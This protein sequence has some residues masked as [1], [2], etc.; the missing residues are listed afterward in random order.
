MSNIKVANRNTE[1]Q[2]ESQADFTK[3]NSSSTSVNFPNNNIYLDRHYQ[4][5]RRKPDLSKHLKQLME[6]NKVS[7][8]QLSKECAIPASTLST[9]LSGK[10]ASYS[11]DHLAALADY[12]SVSLDYLMFGETSGASSLNS[13]LTEQIFDGYLKVKVER[14]I[15]NNKKDKGS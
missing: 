12:F 11:P 6:I 8:T 15:P 2:T 7:S 3:M 13:L 1:S 4:E 9:Y 5:M 14:V 10:K